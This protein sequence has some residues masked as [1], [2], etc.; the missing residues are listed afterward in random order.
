METNE[1][2]Y[3][4]LL[5]KSE[6]LNKRISQLEQREAEHK[7][8]EQRLLSLNSLKEQIICTPNFVDKLRLITDGV[9]D[10]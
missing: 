7:Q 6:T 2:S 3:K 5:K 1:T 4:K 8:I 9:V 10:I